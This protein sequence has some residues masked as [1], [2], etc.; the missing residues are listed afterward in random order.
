[1]CTDKILSLT[2]IY[3]CFFQDFSTI[4]SPRVIVTE[5]GHAQTWHNIGPDFTTAKI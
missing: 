3:I 5:G 2:Y 1:M 4:G